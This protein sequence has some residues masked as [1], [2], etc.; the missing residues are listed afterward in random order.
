MEAKQKFASINLNKLDSKQKEAL[1]RFKTI[2]N[3]FKSEDK[4]LMMKID[5]ALDKV[6]DKL[7]QSN[8]DAIKGA[9]KLQS[10]ATTKAKRSTTKKTQKAGAS[11]TASSSS[12]SRRTLMTVAKEIRKQG[13]SWSDALNR[14]KDV[15]EKEKQQTNVVIKTQTD[16]LLAFIKRKKE[17][18]GLSGTT[19]RK[20]AKIEA[21][22]KGRRV[23]RKGWKNQHGESDGGRVYY[24]NRDN[25]SDRLAPNFAD[26]VYLADGGF[27]PD[28]SDG[29]QFM[30]GVYADGG[31]VTKGQMVWNKLTSS[32]RADFLKE[33]FTPEITPRSQEI[34]VGKTFKFLPRNVK[35]K[36]ESFYADVEDYANGGGGTIIKKGNRVRIVNTQYDD[37]EGLVVSNDLHNGQY[38]VQVDG[39]VLGFSFENLMLLS[40]ETYANGG[41][42][43]DVKKDIASLKSS[44]I[45]KAKTRGIYENFG[46]KEVGQLE[47]KYGYNKDVAD[48]DNWCMDFDLSELKKYANGG[49]LSSKTTYIPNRDVKELHVVL[50]GELLKLSG[51]DVVDGVYAK[52]TSLKTVK[53]KKTTATTSKAKA[54]ASAI[55]IYKKLEKIAKDTDS[56]L[57]LEVADVQ[58]LLDAG[59]VEKDIIAIYEG[60]TPKF[61]NADTEFGKTTSG[62]NNSY[63]KYQ[64]TNVNEIIEN[65]NKDMFEIGLRYPDFDWKAIANKFN[66]DLTPK[67]KTIDLG[68]FQY[69]YEYYLGNGIIIG[70]KIANKRKNDKNWRADYYTEYGTID[71]SKPNAYQDEREIKAGF[72]GGYWGIV[73]RKKEDAYY[74]I[75]TLLKQKDGYVKDMEIFTNGLGGVGAREAT[76]ESFEAGGSLIGI[77]ET[78]LANAPLPHYTGLVGETGAMASGEMFEQGGSLVDGY[79]TDPNFGNFQNM[80]FAD[81]GEIN[82]KN[83]GNAKRIK[84]KNWYT[85]TYPTDEIGKEINSNVSLWELWS[86]M[87]NGYNVYDVLGV[88]DSMVRERVFEK[89]SETLGVK[90]DV[91]YKKWLSSISYELGGDTGL[92]AG[93]EQQFANYYLGEGASAGIFA[94]GGSIENQ[95]EGKSAEEVWNMLSTSQKYHFLNDHSKEI[96]S[97]PA[98]IE[99]ATKTTYSFLP[100]KFKNAFKK[101]VSES[102]YAK[103]GMF[104]NGGSMDSKFEAGV[105]R[106]GKPI[107]VST[108]LYEQKIVEVFDN[109]DIATASDYGRSL[110]DFKSMQ[111]PTISKEKLDSMYMY[112]GDFFKKGGALLSTRERYVAEL[113]GLTGLRQ[114]A[115]DNFIDENQ[116]TD[117]E[118]LNIVIGLG[119][120]QI[121]AGSVS[122]AIVGTKGNTEFK[123]LI[124][125]AKSDK[126][127]KM[128]DGGMFT[129]RKFLV[130][131]IVYNKRTNTIGIVRLPEE[132]G[133]VKTDADGN[134][135][136]DELEIYNPIVY[137]HQQN[138]QV[139]PSTY[140]E[141]EKKGGFP[142]KFASYAKGG[143]LKS[144]LMRDRKY[145][146]YS[147]D[148]EVRYSKGKA[149]RKG[150][151]FEDGG[152]MNDSQMPSCNTSKHRNN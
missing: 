150:Y 114:N 100:I 92:P 18:E 21:M 4:Q 39:K 111:Y 31:F 88:R 77:A 147:E 6:I 41:G 82:R 118:I 38:Q 142:L 105:Y 48:F 19:V 80:M 22:P 32:K 106:V 23:S 122:T 57:G 83:V 36:I 17:L 14:A 104:A 129:K 35:I 121:S 136:V 81:G 89:L 126:A 2:S 98:S 86:Y 152:M 141:I 101:H 40:R 52:N 130:D 137:K 55:T 50:K 90:Y 128:N 59:F 96:E 79:L 99:K 60:Y 148:H 140:E 84:I 85:K 3:N 144:A 64:K 131:D 47:D 29:T 42:V 65:A 7:K 25:R 133:E 110:S 45:K 30:D 24:E 56:E 63:A 1:M 61:V 97:T 58:S 78:P 138:P 95:Y 145:K 74:V 11:K 27:T 75:D 107:K 26:K 72:N 49:S 135:N 127:Y 51:D 5:D 112:G 116:L 146:N 16:K 149:H 91:V 120:K 46:Q 113:K 28:V 12:S 34:L 151:G 87:S 123:K 10:T 71:L 62:L 37:K 20:D 68:E 66:I 8:P 13:E 9:K 117:N 73:V 124:A 143:R 109:G 15:F 33:Y 43:G 70:H 125:F 67:H 115:I 54:I 44:L 108:N 102:Q 76:G 132:R 103:G 53:P 94:K 139:A 69:K 134:V 93:A 119:R